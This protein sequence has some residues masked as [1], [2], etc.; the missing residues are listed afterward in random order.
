MNN[1]DFA[2]HG[3]WYFCLAFDDTF[4]IKNIKCNDII[5][6]EFKDKQRFE[7]NKNIFSNIS[8]KQDMKL[9]NDKFISMRQYISKY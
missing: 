8:L 3:K 7:L 2:S 1:T 6:F 5:E 9:Y 4:C